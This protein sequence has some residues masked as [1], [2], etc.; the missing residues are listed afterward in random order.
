MDAEPFTI[1]SGTISATYSSHRRQTATKE[2]VIVAPGILGGNTGEHWSPLGITAPH[3]PQLNMYSQT[4]VLTGTYPAQSSGITIMA[5]AQSLACIQSMNV[6]LL[7]IPCTF[8]GVDGFMI[9]ILVS[10]FLEMI[11]F[12]AMLILNVDES[13]L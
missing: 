10:D 8:A 5:P 3:D 13:S 4:L 1:L 12:F 6:S 7:T 2:E 11:R 9:D